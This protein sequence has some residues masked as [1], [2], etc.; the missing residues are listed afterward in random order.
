VSAK[1]KR[2]SGEERRRARRTVIQESFNLFL[3]IPE[4]LGMARIYLRDVSKLGLSFRSEMD[5]GLKK[6]QVITA[7]VYLNPAFY[8]PIEAKVM[9]VQGSEFGVEFQQPDHA[10]VRALAILQDFIDAAEKSGVLVE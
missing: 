1:S 8:L 2:E 5:V 7:R 3:V 9:R 4:A 10:A 6:D